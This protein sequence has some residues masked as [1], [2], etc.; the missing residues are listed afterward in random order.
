MPVNVY[1]KLIPGQDPE[2]VIIDTYEKLRKTSDEIK[3][4]IVYVKAIDLPRNL[5]SKR[6]YVDVTINDK[7]YRIGL[8]H[9]K[10]MKEI[11]NAANAGDYTR[12]EELQNYM[13]DVILPGIHR[14]NEVDLK[15]IRDELDESLFLNTEDPLNLISYNISKVQYVSLNSER[16]TTNNYSNKFGIPSMNFAEILQRKESYFKEKLLEKFNSPDNINLENAILLYP[17]NGKATVI[18]SDI[19]N[20]KLNT[21]TEIE[22]IINEEGYRIDRNQDTLYK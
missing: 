11:A 6:A 14:Q 13:N 19:N 18:V 8:W 4:G 9:F 5:R 2:I 21:T 17:S 1:Y 7:V 16:I 3:A 10:T 22:P 12:K 20:Y 15:N